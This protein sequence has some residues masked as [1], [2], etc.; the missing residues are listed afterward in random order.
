METWV[1][2]ESA[3]GGPAVQFT[4]A[5]PTGVRFTE[6]WLVDQQFGDAVAVGPIR[7]QVQ[8]AVSER[9]VEDFLAPPADALGDK[10]RLTM[11]LGEA[12]ERVALDQCVGQKIPLGTSGVEVEIAAYLPNAVPDRLGNFTTKGQQPKNPMLELRV[13]LPGENQPIRQIA[14]AKDPLLNLDGVYPRV[15]P[16]KFRFD[17]AAVQPQTAVELLQTSAGTLLGRL[18]SAGQYRLHGELR[19]GDQLDL[20]GRFQLKIVGHLAHAKRKVTFTPSNAATKRSAR[21]PIAPAALVEITAGGK[22]E[23]IWL[24]RDDPAYGR[25]TLAMPGGVLALSYECPRRPLEFSLMLEESRRSLSP[26]SAGNVAYSSSVRVLDSQRR[27]DQRHV[28][29]PNR[30]LTYRNYSVYH[31]SLER[32]PHDRKASNFIVA[33][34][35]GRTLKYGGSVTIGLGIA[36]MFCMR[37]KFFTRQRNKSRDGALPPGCADNEPSQPVLRRAA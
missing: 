11:Y 3:Q 7:L 22:V 15:C 4:A 10:G 32:A 30:S 26:K 21:D 5:G 29:S 36:I 17:H 31:V 19:P 25:S 12:V 33:R 35:P 16:V 8:Q 14:F 37:A 24:C 2:D 9:M 6:G 23:Q 1:A 34:D 13:Y 20:P 18:C 28:I 27:L